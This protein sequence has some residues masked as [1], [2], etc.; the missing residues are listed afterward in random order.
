MELEPCIRV[1]ELF[2]GVGGFRIGLERASSKFCTVWSNQWEPSTK[3]QDASGIY[4]ARFGKDGHSNEDICKIDV[5][6]IPEADMVVGGFPCLTGDT[7]VLTKRG[8]VRI[9]QITTRDTVLSHDGTYQPVT[10]TFNQGVHKIYTIS[11][12]GFD[13]IKATD[14][15][16]FF[17]RI[18]NTRYTHSARIVSY[19]EPDW[20]TV[21]QLRQMKRNTVYFGTPINTHAIMPTWKGID[22]HTNA[23]ATRHLNNLDLS[24]PTLWYI[25]GLYIGNG[26]LHKTPKRTE[27][28][29][30]Y[31]CVFIC[32]NLKK[33]S[34]L[35]Q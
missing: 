27:T 17:A 28:T 14:N 11:G 23:M 5:D 19:S 34:V 30:P 13:A 4:V 3:K 15:H 20:F 33:K 35:Y 10:N 8:L 24:D 25:A 21:D 31:D 12:Y 7:L 22:V 9:D 18:K 16:K 2:A 6:R 29:H 1:I 32:G 26:W